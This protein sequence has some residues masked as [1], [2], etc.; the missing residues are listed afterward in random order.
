MLHVFVHPWHYI[1]SLNHKSIHQH[2]HTCILMSYNISNIS[3][4][5]ITIFC[6]HSIKLV[7]WTILI[8][9]HSHVQACI[10]CLI[11]HNYNIYHQDGYH[12]II[13]H[14]ITSCCLLY[15]HVAYHVIINELIRHVIN[16][17]I[18]T[19]NY[20]IRINTF[21]IKGTTL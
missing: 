21:I 2:V 12:D 20:N 7:P 9:E 10:L 5:N 17:S 8:H 14:I 6:S 3:I 11:T 13:L 16:F 19:K 4:C 1:G 18:I 15:Y